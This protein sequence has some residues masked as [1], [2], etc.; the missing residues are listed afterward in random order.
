MAGMSCLS[1][2]A[3]RRIL[4]VSV[5]LAA[6]ALPGWGQVL[7]TMS[8]FNGGGAGTNDI[9]T[10]SAQLWL[11]S[12]CL[13]PQVAGQGVTGSDCY[14]VGNIGVLPGNLGVADVVNAGNDSD[15]SHL[16]GFFT[17]SGAGFM[18]NV[19]MGNG[20]SATN[21]GT[22]ASQFPGNHNP[23]FAGD[24]ITALIYKIASIPTD[25]PTLVIF[26]YTLAVD[27][28][29]AASPEPRDFFPAGAERCWRCW[30]ASGSGAGRSRAAKII[31]F[32]YFQ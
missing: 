14:E 10:Y 9:S 4:G 26:Q 3:L 7:G 22:L 8:S 20:G 12:N 31:N 28:A 1:R 17:S 2:V 15:F 21:S 30:Q 6:A 11:G 32:I 16:A 13:A 19:S 5:G 25:T 29:P 27:G 18:S 23:P 24:N